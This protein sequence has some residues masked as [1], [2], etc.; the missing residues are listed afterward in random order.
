MSGIQTTI[1]PWLLLPWKREDRR[2][3][4]KQSILRLTSFYFWQKSIWNGWRFGGIDG[5]SK[6]VFEITE[7]SYETTRK[8]D[9]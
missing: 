6:I 9:N 1:L 8:I 7:R 3:N 5:E 2:G 4:R